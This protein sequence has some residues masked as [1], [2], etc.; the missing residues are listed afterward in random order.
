[1]T[2]S[3][4]FDLIKTNSS[5]IIAS[6]IMPDGDSIGSVLAMTAFL[7]K[8]GKRTFPVINDFIPERFLFLPGSRDISSFTDVFCDVVICLDSGDE[9]RLGF[10]K[11]LRDFGKIVVNIDHHKTND[12]Y[13]DVNYVDPEASSTGEILYDFFTTWDEIDVNIALSLYT[14]II[15]DT[16]SIKYSNTTAKTLRILA[17][18]VDIGVKPEVV[19]RHV[20]EN[21]TLSS[22]KLLRNYLQT[23]EFYD[24]GKIAFSYLTKKM[25]D[26]T[27]AT[28]EDA[29][30]LIKWPR[31]IQGVE[32]A[33]L[34]REMEPSIIKVGLRSNNLVDVSR[35]AE[36]FNGGGH[37]KAAGC[38]LNTSL[39]K[40]RELM[41]EAIRGDIKSYGL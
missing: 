8:L 36:G 1:M 7:K 39:D 23:I 34:F 20:F 25:L 37:A 32:V 24:D 11:N 17:H 41:L 14:A 13:G 28:E 31:E 26:E 15:T 40:A 30:G 4:I 10:D 27:G 22:L 12:N 6:H 18:L 21:R 33:V 2:F 9:A 35:I 19:S 3:K 16:G 29:D 5:F 38:S